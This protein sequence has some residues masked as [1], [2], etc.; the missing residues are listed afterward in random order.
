MGECCHSILACVV[1]VVA[2]DATA[3]AAAAVD[4][5]PSGTAP[6]E[7]GVGEV[8]GEGESSWITTT[9]SVAEELEK[10]RR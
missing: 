3:A 2:T 8:R 10:N 7:T 5:V 4:V 9:S 6:G 1:V